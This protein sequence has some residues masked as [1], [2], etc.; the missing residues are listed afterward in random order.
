MSDPLV[1]RIARLS[2]YSDLLARLGK[3]AADRGDSDRAYDLGV[4]YLH[5]EHVLAPLLQD[6]DAPAPAEGD[7]P[8]K[9]ADGV[10]FTPWAWR[11]LLHD[12][13]FAKDHVVRAYVI[14]CPRPARKRIETR[15]TIT[16]AFQY[17]VGLTDMTHLWVQWSDG[18]R[19]LVH[20]K[21]L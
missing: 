18:K 2:D 4:R 14:G 12:T 20:R 13:G 1:H 15:T 9:H 10:G 19:H 16:L 8:R 6:F 17:Y 3:E 5:V 7:E 11:N 21:G